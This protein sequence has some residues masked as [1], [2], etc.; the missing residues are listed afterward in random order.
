MRMK[1]ALCIVLVICTAFCLCGCDMLA[2]NTEELVSP[3]ALTGDMYPIGNALDESIEV[4]YTLEYPTA[5]DNRSAVILEDIDSDGYSEAFAFYSTSDDEMT[6]MHINVIC[7]REQEWVSVATHSMV[8]VG[9]ERVSFSDLNDDGAKEIIIG[10]EIYGSSDKQL[11][12]YT[13]SDEILTQRLLQQYS[14]FVCCDL[15]SN[16]TEEVFVHLL[17][18]SEGIN[19]ASVY[20]YDKTGMR[21]TAGCIMDRNVK[22]ASAP[23]LSTLS[24]GQNAIYIDEVK[25]IGAVTEVLFLS[26]GELVNPLLDTENTYEN[27][28]T[29][30]AA[31]LGIEDINNDGIIEIPVAS[32]LPTADLSAEKLYYT[33]WS[34]F[35]GERLSVKCVTVV[36]TVDGYYL[37]IPNRLVGNIAVAKDVEKHK[38]SFYTY[39]SSDG[40]VGERLFTIS[41]LDD[42]KQQE[43]DSPQ[44]E[45]IYRIDET[46]FTVSINYEQT[47]YPITLEEVKEMFN[48]I[49]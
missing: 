7:Q 19:R 11:G 31:V 32:D 14:G 30:R 24:T 9:V 48:I 49:V 3:P 43:L 16:G 22:T 27:T 17:N 12:I 1:K 13:F 8:A 6:T 40:K 47:I 2:V 25:G 18:T 26:K 20:S 21:E 5:G 10:W 34:S 36:N 33:N 28:I 35:N 45:E 41:V 44:A 42:W 15:D 46:V 37:K 29:L 38:R 39:N 4:D 23:V